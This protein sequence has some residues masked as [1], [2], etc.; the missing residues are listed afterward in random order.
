MWHTA[1]MRINVSSYIPGTSA[2]HACDAR[3]K[4]VLLAALSFAIGKG[5]FAAVAAWYGKQGGVD[6]RANVSMLA[7][8]A[9]GMQESPVAA[10][11]TTNTL[12]SFL[13]RM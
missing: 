5:A 13:R 12:S 9:M 3:V 8:L 6:F 1:S 10:A 2:V 11:G 4:I 7:R